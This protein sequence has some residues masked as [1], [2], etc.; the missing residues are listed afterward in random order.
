LVEYKGIDFT[1][2]EFVKLLPEALSEKYIAVVKGFLR[3]INTSTESIKNY[4]T[5]IA[6]TEKSGDILHDLDKLKEYHKQRIR[7][8]E[9][10]TASLVIMLAAEPLVKHLADQIKEELEQ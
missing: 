1:E 7:H 6:L 3:Q 4:D 2:S 8:R 5:L 9:E 10:Q